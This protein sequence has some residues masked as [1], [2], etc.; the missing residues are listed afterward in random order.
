VQNAILFGSPEIQQLAEKQFNLKKSLQELFIKL[1]NERLDATGISKWHE[2]AEKEWREQE[3]KTRDSAYSAASKY[4]RTLFISNGHTW[5]PVSIPWVQLLSLLH[6]HH[7]HLVGWPLEEE[8]PA[9][10]PSCTNKSWEGGQW[11]FLITEFQKGNSCGIKLKRWGNDDAN[12]NTAIPLVIDRDGN[13]VRSV[14]DA[15]LDFRSESTSSRRQPKLTVQK[16]QKAL[17]AAKSKGT[18][19]SACI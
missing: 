2:E 18:A 14:Q 9:P 8:C 15:E 1:M 4:L 11:R 3:L 7:V 6:Q 19:K 13:V 16:F 5:F 12:D 17:A 10:H